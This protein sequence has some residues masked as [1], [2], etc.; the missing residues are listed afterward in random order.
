MICS[1]PGFPVYLSPQQAKL[2]LR[3]LGQCYQVSTSSASAVSLPEGT[4]FGSM[5]NT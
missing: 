1:L 4:I 2:E 3:L 5:C